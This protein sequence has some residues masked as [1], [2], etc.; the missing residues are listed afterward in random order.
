MPSARPS[1]QPSRP[2]ST[3]ASLTSS[4]VALRRPKRTFSITVVSNRNGSCG[5]ITRVSRSE[6]IRTSRRS[7]PATRTAPSVGSARRV[8]S[9]ASVD[10]PEPVAPTTATFV[11]ERIVNVTSMRAGSTASAA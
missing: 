10:L 9:L 7:I 3:K 5:T 2:S 8:S 4:S 11:A 1:T 6:A